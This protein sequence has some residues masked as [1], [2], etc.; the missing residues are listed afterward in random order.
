M[1]TR[2]LADALVSVVPKTMQL[3]RAE[4]RRSPGEASLTQYRILARL[5]ASPRSNS[6]LATGLG[7]SRPAMTRQMNT[8]VRLGWVARIPARDDRR[9]NHLTATPRG[10]KIFKAMREEVV[11][12]FVH[13][14]EGLDRSERRDLEAGVA[15]LARLLAERPTGSPK[16]AVSFRVP[17]ASL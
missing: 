9:K 11:K 10:E 17:E 1:V 15:A 7:V 16:S 13:R 4:I 12:N 5:R 14:I 6:E 8:M 2:D 3:I